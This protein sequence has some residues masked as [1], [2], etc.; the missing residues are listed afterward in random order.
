MCVF[1]AAREYRERG[2]GGGYVVV[3]LR[4]RCVCGTM[5]GLVINIGCILCGQRERGE[6]R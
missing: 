4:S 6:A 2:G 1:M 3:L 5:Q